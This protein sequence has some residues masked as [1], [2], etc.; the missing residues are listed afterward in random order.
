MRITAKPDS[1]NSQLVSCANA[2][3]LHTLRPTDPY[4]LPLE[5]I[6]VTPGTAQSLCHLHLSWLVSQSLQ[7]RQ[8]CS[9]VVASGQ[10]PCLVGTNNRED[11]S[12]DINMLRL[13][14]CQSGQQHGSTSRISTL[15]QNTPFRS[16]VKNHQKTLAVRSL[17]P[18]FKQWRVPFF[19]KNRAGC[20]CCNNFLHA[21]EF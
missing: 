21:V 16:F 18:V 13:R 19:W 3:L 10:S 17:F 14:G 4:I 7:K 20:E 5:V 6:K 8:Y 1:C 9:F 2:N 11:Q 12:R 15:S